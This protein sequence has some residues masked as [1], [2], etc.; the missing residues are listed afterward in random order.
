MCLWR[1]K[2]IPLRPGD[3]FGTYAKQAHKRKRGKV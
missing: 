3:R 2:D 1:G